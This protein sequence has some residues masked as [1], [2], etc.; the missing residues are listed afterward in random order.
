MAIIRN[1]QF[2]GTLLKMTTRTRLYFILN[3]TSYFIDKI[4]FERET[5]PTSNYLTG[6]PHYRTPIM[7]KQRGR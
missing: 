5:V 3:A 4:L 7:E 2:N 6:I 1:L